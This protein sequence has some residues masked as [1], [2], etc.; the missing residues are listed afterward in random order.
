MKKLSDGNPFGAIP[1]GAVWEALMCY[2]ESENHLDYGGY[3]GEALLQFKTTD[4]IK[5]G[6]S[7]DLNSNVVER[8]SGRMPKGTRLELIKKGEKL[9]L[10]DKSV[11]TISAI[12]VVEHIADQKAVLDEFRRVLQDDG[13][14]ILAVPGKHL[15]SFLDTQASHRKMKKGL[16]DIL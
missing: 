13:I 14:L 10:A 5:G 2:G 8:N 7:F 11:S 4:L 3:D 15:F 12:G 16:E 1:K 6:V 9:P